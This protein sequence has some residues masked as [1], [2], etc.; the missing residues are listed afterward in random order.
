VNQS[1][2]AKPEEGERTLERPCV[3]RILII[4]DDDVMRT[5]AVKGLGKQFRVEILEAKNGLEGL[6]KAKRDLPSLILLDYMMPGVDGQLTL[7]RIRQVPDL[8]EVPVI[9]ISAVHDRSV[10][11]RFAS[12]NIAGYLAKPFSIDVLVERIRKVLPHL[13]TLKEP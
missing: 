7:A 5:I 8:K 4:D 3:P 13:S 2:T 6:A 1:D 12:F 11:T 9:I 10:I